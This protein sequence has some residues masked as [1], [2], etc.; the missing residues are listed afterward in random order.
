MSARNKP[1]KTDK[2]TIPVCM[3]GKSK[4][5]FSNISCQHQL[6]DYLIFHLIHYFLFMKSFQVLKS[7]KLSGKITPGAG[8]NQRSI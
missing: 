7:K 5:Y 3:Y 2:Q 4:L 8:K 6:R 1:A